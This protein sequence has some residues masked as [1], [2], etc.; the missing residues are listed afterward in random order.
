MLWTCSTWV[1][2]THL[3]LNWWVTIQHQE[4]ILMDIYVTQCWQEPHTCPESSRLP[5]FCFFSR[6]LQRKGTGW[7]SGSSVGVATGQLRV[8]QRLRTA[9]SQLLK[10]SEQVIYKMLK[11]RNRVLFWVARGQ[12]IRT[13]Q[14]LSV[15]SL[16]FHY[17]PAGRSLQRNRKLSWS[18]CLFGKHNSSR[19]WCDTAAHT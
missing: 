7:A 11:A 9:G 3:S 1:L 2:G 16:C 8:G 4:G 10:D 18:S 5:D 17:K 15:T 14:G 13:S 19:G 12:L 6:H